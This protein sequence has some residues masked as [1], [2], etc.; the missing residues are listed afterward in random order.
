M[1]HMSHIGFFVYNTF[2]N[3]SPIP[4][5]L[6]PE[7]SCWAYSPSN[8]DLSN[9]VESDDEFPQGGASGAVTTPNR[10][11]T[12]LAENSG[13]SP[14]TAQDSRRASPAVGRSRG[15]S[16]PSPRAT[17]EHTKFSGMLQTVYLEVPQVQ[18]IELHDLVVDNEERTTSVINETKID[19][20]SKKKKS[21]PSSSTSE[22][23][24]VCR[25]LIFG[26]VTRKMAA[27]TNN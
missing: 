12:P 9:V 2:Q 8:V 13:A 3:S 17:P 20:L 24:S 4:S 22:Q 26:P 6:R 19:K 27:T 25:P 15:A 23:S 7:D 1:T 11:L 10:Q 5:V 21:K 16:S 14:A 18:D